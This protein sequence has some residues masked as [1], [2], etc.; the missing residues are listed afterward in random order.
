MAKI[1]TSEY[2][3]LLWNHIGL[4]TIARNDPPIVYKRTDL[5]I[6]QEQPFCAQ[7]RFGESDVYFLSITNPFLSSW[8]R[9]PVA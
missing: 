8:H 4:R 6:H 5:E 2:Y 1:E 3:A 7:T 9:Y